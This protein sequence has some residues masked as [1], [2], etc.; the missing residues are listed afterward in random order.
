MRPKTKFRCIGAS[1]HGWTVKLQQWCTSFLD[2]CK[3][4]GEMTSGKLWTKRRVWE[5]SHCHENKENGALII[6]FFLPELQCHIAIKICMHIEK[7]FIFD[8]QKYFWIFSFLCTIHPGADEIVI[9]YW[10]RCEAGVCWILLSP[11][12][13]SSITLHYFFLQWEAT[14][15]YAP[16]WNELYNLYAKVEANEQTQV[17]GQ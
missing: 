13:S 4:H 16:H 17:S 12:I 15:L 5:G 10:F 2:K 11:C 7:L 9:S 6:L 8:V 1:D 3:S 14:Y